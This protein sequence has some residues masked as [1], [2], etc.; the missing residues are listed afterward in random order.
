MKRLY[1][2]SDVSELR[3]TFEEKPEVEKDVGAERVRTEGEKVCAPGDQ[4]SVPTQADSGASSR[5]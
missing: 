3:S 1:E 4:D 5:N 2:G